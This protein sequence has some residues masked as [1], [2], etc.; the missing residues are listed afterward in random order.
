MRIHGH[1]LL[2]RSLQTAVLTALVLAAAAVL[3]R[4]P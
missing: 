3:S 4:F 2:T 1:P